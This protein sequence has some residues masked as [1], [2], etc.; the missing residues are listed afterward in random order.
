MEL[1]EIKKQLKDGSLTL[2]QTPIEFRSNQEVVLEA[3]AC[4]NAKY[5][6][7]SALNFA[8]DNLRFERKLRRFCAFRLSL[9]SSIHPLL[10]RV[11]QQHH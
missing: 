3:L 4:E 5:T 10:H 8:S 9:K 2:E 6:G 7:R 1:Q 11:L